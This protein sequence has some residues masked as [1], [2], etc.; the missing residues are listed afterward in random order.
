MTRI[1]LFVGGLKKGLGLALVGALL[2]SC[3]GANPLDSFIGSAN[4][5]ANKYVRFDP[6]TL[7]F[8]NSALSPAFVDRR[9]KIT[10]ISDQP[11]FIEG[12]VTDNDE[13]EI[14]SDDCAK[15]PL[16]LDAGSDCEVRMRFSPEA[17]GD[18]EGVLTLTFGLAAASSTES[19]VDL[20]LAGRSTADGVGNAGLE[21]D[22]AIYDF[23]NVALTPAFQD[24]S[25]QVENVTEGN[26]FLSGFS[27]NSPQFTVQSHTCAEAPQ[28]IES[29]DTCTVVLRFTALVTGTH[30]AYLTA[31]YG[32][33]DLEPSNLQARVAV[34]GSSNAGN[35]GNPAVVFDPDYWDFGEQALNSSSE[36]TF[37]VT[38]DSASTVFI[39]EIDEEDAATDVSVLSTDCPVGLNPFP[40]GETCEVTVRYLPTSQGVEASDIEVKYGPTVARNTE[41]INR[42]I[43]AGRSSP[44]PISSASITFTPTFWDYGDVARNQ[45]QAKTITIQNTSVNPLYLD[46]IE[47]TSAATFA[48]SN[49]DCPILGSGLAAGASCQVNVIYTPT[50]D[51]SFS[52]DLTVSYGP[53]LGQA[54]SIE[55]KMVLIGRST[56]TPI[57]NAVPSFS[58]TFKDFGNVSIGS[59]SPETITISN[60]PGSPSIFIG[61]LSSSDSDFLIQASTC[62]TGATS[63]AA[64]SSCTFTLRYLPS[65][66]GSESADVTLLYGL[67]QA[68]NTAL[69]RVLTAAGRSIPPGLGNSAYTF[70]PSYWDFGDVAAGVTVQKVIQVT[71]SSSDS[72]FISNI[73]RTNSAIFGVSHD[74]PVSPTALAAAATCELT[75]SFSPASDGSQSSLASIVYGPT[76]GQSGLLTARVAVAGR[77]TAASRGNSALSF[78]PA[79]WDFGDVPR[80]T[81]VDKVIRITNISSAPA[82]LSATN[83]QTPGSFQVFNNPCPS[84]AVALAAGDNC[85]VTIRFFPAADTLEST[86]LRTYNGPDQ[87]RSGNLL[88]TMVL[89]G[90]SVAV[91]SGQAILSAAP[92]FHDFGDVAQT[93]SVSQAVVLTNTSSSSAYISSITRSNTGAFTVSHNCPISPTAFAAA[94]TCTVT[95]GF[96]PNAEG[97]HTTDVTVLHGPAAATSSNLSYIF[98]AQ[99]RSTA[100]ATGNTQLTFTPSFNDF[101]DIASGAT[102]EFDVTI[103]NSGSTTLFLGAVSF[104]NARFSQVSN[105]CLGGAATLAAG[106]TCVARLRFS[107]VADGAQTGF[108]SF[109]Y[110]PDAARR[111]NLVARMPLAGRSTAAPLGNASITY[112]PST[113]DYGDVADG[114]SAPK[115]FTITNTY[116]S[117]LHVSGVTSSSARF[118]LADTC[119]RSPT[120]LAAGATCT[121]TVTFSPNAEGGFSS[122]ISLDYGPDAARSANLHALL[123]VVGR[124]ISEPV[125]NAALVF[126]PSYDDFGNIAA[127]DDESEV[128]EL[129]NTKTSTYFLGGASVTLAD[130][131]ITTNTCGATLAASATC[132]ITVKY[133]PSD[134]GTDIGELRMAYGPDAARQNN[135]VAKSTLIAKS[136]PPPIGNSAVTLSPETY[137]FGSVGLSPAFATT[138]ITLSNASTRSLYIGPMTGFTSPYSVQSTTCPT[139]PTAIAAGASCSIVVR[140]E[141]IAGPQVSQTLTVGYGV[142]A[143]NTSEYNSQAQFTGRSNPNPPTNFQFV[144]GTADQIDFSWAA[145]DFDQSSFEIERC[146]GAGCATTFV[147]AESDDA[148]TFDQRSYSATG[149]TEG[150]IYR[151]RIRGVAGST[152]STWLTGPTTIAFGGITSVDNSQGLA[153]SLSQIDCDAA[154]TTG[155][156]VGLYWNNVANAAYYQV[157]DMSSGSAVFVR[158]VAAGSS[159]TV[160]TGLASGANRDYLVR[161]FT[162]SGVGSINTTSSLLTSIEFS[163][164][165]VIGHSEGATANQRFGFNQLR[166]IHIYNGKMF[167]ADQTNHRV[168][169]WNSVPTSDMTPPDVVIGQ[170]D[171]DSFTANNSGV[172]TAPP[173]LSAKSLNSPRSVFVRRNQA[174]TADYV[175]VADTA[176]NR[177]LVWDHIPT[178]NFEAATWVL[179]QLSFTVNTALGTTSCALATRNQGRAMNQPHSVFVDDDND[180]YVSDTNNHRIIVW[181]NEIS[182]SAQVAQV[183]LGQ[184]STGPVDLT[185]GGNCPNAALVTQK[186]LNAPTNVY[187]SGNDVFVADTT[188]SRI[189]RFVKPLTDSKPAANVIGQVNFT[190]NGGACANNRLNNPFGIWGDST[191]GASNLYVA[192]YSNHRVLR[193]GSAKFGDTQP[194]FDSAVGQASLVACGAATTQTGLNTPIMGYTGTSGAADG[195][196]VLSYNLN[197]ITKYTQAAAA[198]FSASST[199]LLGQPRYTII[200][201]RFPGVTSQRLSRPISAFIGDSGPTPRSAVVDYGANRVLLYDSA[202]KAHLPT[203]SRVLGQTTMAGNLD[204]QNGSTTVPAANTFYQP[205]GVWTDGIRLLVADTSNNRILGWRSWPTSTAQNADYVLGQNNFITRGAG[206]GTNQLNTPSSVFVSP[207]SGGGPSSVNIWVADRAN[208]RVVVYQGTWNDTVPKFP[209]D[210]GGSHSL[211]LGHSATSG[212]SGARATQD[213]FSSPR[214]VWSDGVRVVVADTGNHRVMIW[215]G[216]VT[217]ITGEAADVVLGQQDFTTATSSASSGITAATMNTPTGVFVDSNDRLFVVDQANHRVLLWND[218]DSLVTGKDADLILGQANFISGGVNGGNTYPTFD[219]FNF[220]T[221]IFVNAGRVIL[222]DGFNVVNQQSTTNGRVLVFPSP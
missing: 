120:T 187:V 75:V 108:Y 190:T 9:A 20:G 38:N 32:T 175:Y 54:D 215:N 39:N 64:S 104:S 148:I 18:R 147:T 76:S 21:F 116:S 17:Q 16:Q 133:E 171:F 57:G 30:A 98:A 221:Q 81:F 88:S 162:T 212:S 60:P 130:Y 51:G 142:S 164:C 89:A 78:T 3:S 63:L 128:F 154:G 169:I 195:V 179:G 202:I 178:S 158:N 126:N 153:T 24:R 160:I 96:A 105:A 71:N 42:A 72:V 213:G 135:L 34:S 141:P 219:L 118:T 31:V 23:G 123:G 83:L 161:A 67:D 188:N 134:E 155:S 47:R 62:P 139:A 121:V 103:G 95:L 172:R 29:G 12:F 92:S 110:G 77:S 13:F 74:C 36:K 203:A 61:G 168:L 43:V 91:P 146:D 151:F 52:T 193:L 112:T 217:P 205:Q 101:G 222:S 211:V 163:P 109:T 124:S 197:R 58:P 56:Q 106:A 79:Y 170:P 140:F 87:P 137:D 156:Y 69:N 1:K 129:T 82:Y 189:L 144:S 10:N 44:A 206:N 41:L 173:A 93:N 117:P 136:E 210:N 28:P 145:N 127:G 70:S 159:S 208:H 11:I 107:P 114:Q 35:G 150:Q 207:I 25:F 182:S 33:S 194:V 86:N 157:F 22:P 184:F 94:A 99:G 149:L 186:G 115:V 113:W 45:S 125:G 167:V 73:T 102:S 46:D 176:N 209:L 111:T 40:A 183:V 2:Q 166:G 48:L 97:P 165:A 218:L 5:G 53:N 198:G 132:Q 59:S 26:L 8:G 80:N 66:E 181:T 90:R 177:V 200:M 55:S 14:L 185:I 50:A 65:V 216:S 214:A 27:S 192:D 49:L 37:T 143:L 19:S 180:L 196:W 122:E 15:A 7:S 138:A 199:L 220:P 85:D 201:D 68:R 131:S 100:A 174:N 6:K 152:R 119:P 84:G 204:N 4:E 191:S